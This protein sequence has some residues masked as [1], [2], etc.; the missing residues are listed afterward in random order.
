MKIMNR[1]G[2]RID[3]CGTP[4]ENFPTVR[5]VGPRLDKL[6]LILKIAFDPRQSSV[7]N[8]IVLQFVAQCFMINGIK[9]L[10]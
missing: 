9:R 8:T 5:S 4:D 10:R 2:P 7:T 6:S 1:R 3:P